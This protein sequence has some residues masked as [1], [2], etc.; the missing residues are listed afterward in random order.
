MPITEKTPTS[1]EHAYAVSKLAGEEVVRTYSKDFGV[2]SVI[3]RAPFIVG[4]F[5][6]EKNVLREFIECAEG[7]KSEVTPFS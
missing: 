6:K 7:G 5:Q 2:K 4:E 1:T 3:I